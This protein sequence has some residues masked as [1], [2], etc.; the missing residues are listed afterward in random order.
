MGVTL[1]HGGPMPADVMRDV[2]AARPVAPSSPDY[3]GMLAAIA[4]GN[5]A[6]ETELVKTI[7]PPL[8]LVLR[9][10]APSADVDDL[11]QEA[12]LAVLGAAREGRIKDP[13]ALVQFALE[14]ARWLAC[15]AER[16]TARQRTGSDDAAIDA[17]ASGDM[18]SDDLLSRETRQRGVHEVLNA[19]R[20]PRDRQLLYS[21]YLDEEPSSVLQAKF[22]MNS[23]QLGRVLHR[24]RQRFGE[25][26]RQM[27][28]GLPDE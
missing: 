5:R 22:S 4:A 12:L 3:A 7:S 13:Q 20:N 9:R 6:A 25:V 26:W 11:R 1:I 10:R 16:K 18:G 8:Q 2:A 14:T 27:R 23:V 19:L 21:Y 28:L 15:N 24:A 17:S